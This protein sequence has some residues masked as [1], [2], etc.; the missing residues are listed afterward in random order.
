MIV[1]DNGGD[2]VDVLMW[3]DDKILYSEFDVLFVVCADK[4]NF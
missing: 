3:H 1:V 2:D 4:Y